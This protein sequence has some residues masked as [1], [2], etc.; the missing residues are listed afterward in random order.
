MKKS[1]ILSDLLL[2]GFKDEDSAPVDIK[3]IIYQYLR[4]WWLFVLGVII[5]V[6]LGIAYIFFA[7][8]LYTVSTSMLIKVD[9]GANFT[10]NAVFSD[11][12]AYETNNKIENELE[13]IGSYS[14]MRDAIEDLPLH[15]S[16]FVEDKYSRKREIYGASVPV[17]VVVHEMGSGMIEAPDDRSI[18]VHLN[19]DHFSIEFAED[20]LQQF[21]YG[22]KIENWFGIFSIEK[23]ESFSAAAPTPLIINLNNKDVLAGRF[24]GSLEVELSS[25]FSS[26]VSLSLTDPVS[27]KARDVLNSLVETYNLQA[28]KEKNVIA[29][30]TIEFI[31]EQ[32]K[33]LTKDLNSIER[34]VEAYKRDNNISDLSSEMSAYVLNTGELESQ[35]SR[36]RT[37]IEVLESIEHYLNNP[38]GGGTE[39][40]SS[41]TIDDKTLA[42]QVTRFNDLHNERERYLRT[43]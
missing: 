17:Q 5:F 10:K 22:E 36:N 15:A 37:Q 18:K 14:L 3:F 42:S 25:R 23:T 29:T 24:S 8:P 35:L 1:D 9:E 40:T 32:L 4:Y 19:N 13:V 7:T 11:L 6:A 21:E 39:V 31:D 43:I 30:N 2:D 26:V 41:L 33:A 34:E 20:Q 28:V 27:E 12:E 38:S 16:Y